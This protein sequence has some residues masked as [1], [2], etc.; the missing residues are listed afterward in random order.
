[1]GAEPLTPKS[2]LVDFLLLLLVFFL[3]EGRRSE[4]G[5]SEAGSAW[6]F[7]SVKQYD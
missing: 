1:M 5:V 4:E 3:G 2:Y 6:V 7:A